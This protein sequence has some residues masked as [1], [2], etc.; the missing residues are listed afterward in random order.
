M[1]SRK[2]LDTA[3]TTWTKSRWSQGR[4]R[5]NTAGTTWTKSSSIQLEWPEPSLD[6]LKEKDSTQ[7]ERKRNDLNQVFINTAGMTWTKSRWSQGKDST[8]LERPEPSLDQSATKQWC[9]WL[10]SL[11]KRDDWY[12][13]QWFF[14]RTA[15]IYISCKT[16]VSFEWQY[17]LFQKLHCV[18]K[19]TCQLWRTITTTQF[20][21]F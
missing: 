9:P 20:S 10:T 16:F 5:L 21:R 4:K 8:Q 7:L 18:S 2:R 14:H 11:V 19:K 15:L 6:D 12:N 3:G 1:I 17:K 13:K